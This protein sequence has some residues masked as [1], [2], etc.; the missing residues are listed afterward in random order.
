MGD[1][2]ISKTQALMYDVIE[3]VRGVSC[4]SFGLRILYVES[5]KINFSHWHVNCPIPHCRHNHCDMD[6]GDDEISDPCLKALG[7][8]S[9][10]L[11]DRDLETVESPHSF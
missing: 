5:K 6:S 4:H 8:G 1:G 11:E 3:F 2:E 7:M 10:N 9:T